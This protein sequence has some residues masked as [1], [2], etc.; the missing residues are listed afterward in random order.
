[1]QEEVSAVTEPDLRSEGD[2]EWIAD[3]VQIELFGL[4]AS[5]TLNGQTAEV[6]GFDNDLKRYRVRLL[7]D[8]T[9]KKV[10][11][12]NMRLAKVQ[13]PL[14]ASTTSVP[15]S[16]RSSARMPTPKAASQA[17]QAQGAGGSNSQLSSRTSSSWLRAAM[18]EV[19][20]RTQLLAQGCEARKSGAGDTMDLSDAFLKL[21]VAVER[22]EELRERYKKQSDVSGD[23]D[24]LE[25]CTVIID[26]A[27]VICEDYQQ[28]RTWTEFA[29]DEFKLTQ[30]SIKKNGVVGTLKNEVIEVGRDVADT[31][32]EAQGA[33]RASRE[34]LPDIVASAR[35]SVGA[36][37]TNTTQAAGRA[38]SQRREHASNAIH[39]QVFGPVRRTWHLT[40]FGMFICFVIPLFALRTYAPLNSVVSNLGIVYVIA[41]LCCPPRCA[42]SRASR[43]GLLL[44][45][46]L[47][48]VVLPIWLHYW[49]T[50]PGQDAP[51][52]GSLPDRFRSSMDALGHLPEQFTGRTPLSAP[53]ASDAAEL[54]KSAEVA[55]PDVE[56]RSSG[57]FL[58]KI[59]RFATGGAKRPRVHESWGDIAAAAPKDEN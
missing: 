12:K 30:H 55:F 57:G 14:P 4:Q 16:G 54:A 32:K 33:I 39:E 26:R 23:D 31:A 59:A 36:A 10:G 47:I 43:A 53:W 41:V 18:D 8:D 37:V 38:I 13:E 9:M 7:S 29:T 24:M 51:F 15:S 28:L 58:G 22:I 46:P 20:R 35:G 50:H 2:P 34:Q 56:R 45:Y 11:R 6:I 49:V 42:T 3:G 5:A 27:E 21:A 44:L 40:A 19:R 48:T 52:P 17:V 1:M 25:E